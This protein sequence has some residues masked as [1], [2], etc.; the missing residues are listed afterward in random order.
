M[1]ATMA[2]LGRDIIAQADW[3]GMMCDEKEDAQLRW[4]SDVRTYAKYGKDASMHAAHSFPYIMTPGRNDMRNSMRRML[5]E[6]KR[7]GWSRTSRLRCYMGRTPPPR[8]ASYPHACMLEMKG[9]SPDCPLLAKSLNHRR[10]LATIARLRNKLTDDLVGEAFLY[11]FGTPP[12]CD[13][14]EYA[15]KKRN[16]KALI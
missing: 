8:A 16:I 3:P 11:M 7:E 1:L 15:R 6:L 5:D 9:H 14:W 13:E 4:A 12:T 10:R 2:K